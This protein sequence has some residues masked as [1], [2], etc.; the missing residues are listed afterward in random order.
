MINVIA[1]SGGKDST[2]LLLWAMRT[3]L[4]PRRVV[5]CDTG[6]EHPATLAYVEEI[7]RLT[8]ERIVQVRGPETFEERVRRLRGFPSAGIK[9]CT[10]E[11][12]IQPTRRE[13]DR[14]RDETDDVQVLV[15]VRAEESRKRAAMPE[16]EWSKAYDCEV[17]RPILSWTLADVVAEHHRAGVPLNPLY[18]L[19][20]ERVGCWP[21]INAGKTE[22]ELVARLDPE[23]IDRIRELE[24]VTKNTMFSKE[25]PKS[26]RVPGAARSELP[27]PIDQAVAWSRTERGGVKLRLVPKPSGCER[28]GIC[29]PPTEDDLG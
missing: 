25:A 20:A 2:A 8:G 24:R 28:W 5:F 23:R 13:L 27:L 9:W 26:E 15:G 29:E 14:L 6:W 16:R 12:K 18:R 1:Y 7:E 22:I 10:D 4:T 19:G 11:L 3:G 21:C 17:W